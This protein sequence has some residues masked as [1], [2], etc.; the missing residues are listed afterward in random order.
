MT[1]EWLH[2]GHA[3]FMLLGLYLLRMGL[4]GGFWWDAAM[5][6]AFY[7]WIEHS[8]LL[9]ES[10][11]GVPMPSRWSLGS[12]LMPRIEL[13]FVYNLIA[14]ALMLI[15]IQQKTPPTRESVIDNWPQG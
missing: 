3:L 5:W 10:L 9:G 6:F 7:H 8:L 15:A 13:H 12:F 11:Y 2:Y 14:L 1:S 4:Y